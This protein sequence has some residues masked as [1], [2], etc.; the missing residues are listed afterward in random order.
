MPKKQPPNLL[1]TIYENEPL[2]TTNTLTETNGHPENIMNPLTEGEKELTETKRHR[3]STIYELTNDEWDHIC[4]RN[5]YEQGDK[6]ISKE[7]FDQKIGSL[8]TQYDRNRSRSKAATTG[9]LLTGGV[10]AT[11]ISFAV[12][13]KT[14]IIGL[15]LAH[16]VAALAV[17]ALALT[18]LV[19][20]AMM[21]CK[22]KHSCKKDNQ[23]HNEKNTSQTK[24]F[25]NPYKGIPHNSS[26]W[27][28]C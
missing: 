14:A 22:K 13:H 23:K 28:C 26:C 25:T 15:C 8:F 7:E 21:L 1:A 5:F 17:A 16:P 2:V 11:G 18:V 6:L 19:A 9:M 10:L 3:E 20:S 24:P 12:I 4:D 27:P